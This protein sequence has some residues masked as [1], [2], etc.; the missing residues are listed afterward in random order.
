MSDEHAGAAGS[1]PDGEATGDLLP[2]DLLEVT[3]RRLPR[4]IVVD[5]RGEV[6]AYTRDRLAAAVQAALHE[7]TPIVVIDLSQVGFLGSPGL[8]VLVDAH[9]AAHAAGR[10][11]RVVVAHRRPVIRPLTVTGLAGYL[12][13]FHGL[14]DA[15]TAGPDAL[16]DP[17]GTDPTDRA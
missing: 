11:L 13:L 12:T 15:L 2:G 6:D 16:G 7:S 4:A 9:T 8:A 1:L 5:V 3:T 17:I 10:L 14:A